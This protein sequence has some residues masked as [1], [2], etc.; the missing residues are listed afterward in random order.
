MCGHWTPIVRI[1]P[2]IKMAHGIKAHVVSLEFPGTD[3]DKTV[4]ILSHVAGAWQQTHW[5][6]RQTEETVFP[7]Q[8]LLIPPVPPSASPIPPPVL[9]VCFW[10]PGS[11]CADMKEHLLLFFFYVLEQYNWTQD[12]RQSQTMVDVSE[13]EDVMTVQLSSLLPHERFYRIHC[14]LSLLPQVNLI[15]RSISGRSMFKES[16]IISF[17]LRHCQEWQTKH[18]TILLWQALKLPTEEMCCGGF[19]HSV[20][21]EW[22]K[23]HLRHSGW[24]VFAESYLRLRLHTA[25]LLFSRTTFFSFIL[26]V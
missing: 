11:N 10:K 18:I 6:N 7:P 25:L 4:W 17:K 16:S 22:C 9:T 20:W 24:Q 13:P 3:D 19:F 8:I 12:M 26:M 15:T 5:T 2:Y 23:K 21:M 1:H 14:S